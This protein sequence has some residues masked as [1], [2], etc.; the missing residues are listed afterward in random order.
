LI[1]RIAKFFNVSAAILVDD[2]PI[3]IEYIAAQINLYS[4]LVNSELDVADLARMLSAPAADQPEVL[5]QLLHAKQTADAAGVL[6]HDPHRR[7]DELEMTATVL[8][9]APQAKDADEPA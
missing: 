3:T 5:R 6:E 7:G 2:D 4:A 9:R 1:R 8:F